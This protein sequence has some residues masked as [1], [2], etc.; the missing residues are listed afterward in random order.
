MRA[1]GAEEAAVWAYH[2]DAADE[3]EW[4]PAVY[5][6]PHCAE[7]PYVFDQFVSDESTSCA[8]PTADEAGGTRLG[9]RVT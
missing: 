1:A 4:D 7:L 3:C 6:V 5:G 8:M 2:F 9:V